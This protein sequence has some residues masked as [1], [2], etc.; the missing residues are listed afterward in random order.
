MGVLKG[1]RHRAKP[2]MAS[3]DDWHSFMLTYGEFVML[4][5][6]W[7]DDD[8]SFVEYFTAKLKKIKEEKI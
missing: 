8:L 7:P 2:L 6:Q 1:L 3:E 4:A 5:T